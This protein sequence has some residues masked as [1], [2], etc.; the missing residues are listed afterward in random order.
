MASEE[1]IIPIYTSVLFNYIDQTC[2]IL[3]WYVEWNIN[4]KLLYFIYFCRCVMI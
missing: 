1:I 2:T 4:I 3:M